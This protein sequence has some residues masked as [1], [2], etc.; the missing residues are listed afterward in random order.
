MLFIIGTG[1]LGINVLQGL[2][3][4]LL[5]VNVY[6]KVLDQNLF[7]LVVNAY[8]VWYI[9][10]LEILLKMRLFLELRCSSILEHILEGPSN[11]LPSR[12]T[13]VIDSL[14]ALKVLIIFKRV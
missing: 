3:L 1:V 10:Y 14:Q 13:N 7:D 11:I 6:W 12:H 2:E 4:V 8:L 9:L 5:I